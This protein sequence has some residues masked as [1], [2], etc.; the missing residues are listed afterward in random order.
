MKIASVSSI[1]VYLRPFAR[2]MTL[3]MPLDEKDFLVLVGENPGERL[4]RL[5][6]GSVAE[7]HRKSPMTDDERQT[8]GS[9]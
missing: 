6:A 2:A 8:V 7:G 9:R 3:G 5:P 1:G 4:R